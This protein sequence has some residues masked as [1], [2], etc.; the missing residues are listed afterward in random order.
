M[1][2]SNV[3]TAV[4]AGGQGTR[5]FPYSHPE[6]PKQFCWLNKEDRFIQATIGNFSRQGVKKT[7]ITVLTTNPQQ[8]KLAKE[9]VVP[10][11]ILSQN[12]K[13]ISPEYD[14][15]GA[16]VK[17][18]EMI[19]KHD[20]DAIIISTPSDQYI[21]P[22]ESFEATINHAIEEAAKGNFI[23]VGVRVSDIDTAMGCGHAIFDEKTGDACYD[24]KEFVEKPDR[25]LA[26]RIMRAG[27]SACNTG[28]NVWRAKDLLAMFP[29]RKF[30][31]LATDEL[32]R[33][34]APKLKIAVGDFEWHDCGTLKSLYEANIAIRTP[35]HRNVSFGGG[36][37]DRF[38]CMDGLFLCDEGYRLHVAGSVDDAVIVSTFESHP[39]VAVINKNESARVKKLAE[40]FASITEIRELL[41]HSFSIE[42]QGNYVMR[43]NISR[44]IIVCF[45]CVDNYIVNAY[46]AD[47]GMI[48]VFVGKQSSRSQSL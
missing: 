35:H 29:K 39:I 21:V 24:V 40:K 33:I 44:D 5:L 36:K 34:I 20:E 16:M 10:R 45:V 9:Q 38:E 30:K 4:I 2:K 22:D 48:D 3:W 26:D 19:S 25:K 14:Y 43:S 27:N 6:R 1:D 42:A 8:T 31:G 11:G 32:M 46:R 17:M 15:A 12:I 37:I 18:T 23:I 28:I 13:E 7:Q 41:T 47:D